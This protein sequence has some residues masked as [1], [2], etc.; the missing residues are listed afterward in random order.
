MHFVQV[1]SQAP[2]QHNA[3]LEVASS[4]P[5]LGEFILPHQAKRPRFNM[6]HTDEWEVTVW[7][8][9][10]L[11]PWCFNQISKAHPDPAIWDVGRSSNHHA[12]NASCNSL[13]IVLS[14]EPNTPRARTMP[15]FPASVG[16]S[17]KSRG[18][19]SALA[20]M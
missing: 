12:T 3:R 20:A 4:A 14:R 19:I 8:R 11:W 1:G 9:W 13:N 17:M 5:H 7:I 6:I 15:P 18:V 10:N 2:V 16:A